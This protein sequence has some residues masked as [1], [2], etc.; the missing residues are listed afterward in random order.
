MKYSC[1]NCDGKVSLWVLI[2]KRVRCS[3]CNSKVK[4]ADYIGMLA[5]MPVFLA[6]G[7]S[8]G[9]GNYYI[10]VGSVVFSA[11]LIL[12]ASPSNLVVESEKGEGNVAQ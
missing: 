11:V 7:I 2:S 6:G 3:T 8:Y 9:T 10:L 12:L 1:P 4:V 5:G